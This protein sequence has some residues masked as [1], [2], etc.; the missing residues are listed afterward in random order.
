MTNLPYCSNFPCVQWSIF[1]ASL[2]SIAIMS[3]WGFDEEMVDQIRNC[4]DLPNHLENNVHMQKKECVILQFYDKI[5]N[6][7]NVRKYFVLQKYYFMNS[8][9]LQN[10]VQLHIDFHISLLFRI[11]PIVPKTGT[12]Q[13]VVLSIKG[14]CRHDQKSSSNSAH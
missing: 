10:T 11:V 13:H 2:S 8:K 7:I 3:L 5:H 1:F 6:S 4:T 9:L 14:V 12:E